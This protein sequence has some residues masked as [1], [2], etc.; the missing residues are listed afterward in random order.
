VIFIVVRFQVKPEH[1]EEWPS[2][3][4]SFTKGTRSEA[5]NLWFDWSRSLDDPNEYIL[6][7]AFRDAAAGGAHVST[8]HFH[9]AMRDLPQYLV[10]TPRIIN[11]Q[12]VPGEDWSRLGEMTVE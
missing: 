9:S 12:D 10:E 2:I 5:G 7:E 11:V 4:A 3:V 1:A 8:E 6:V